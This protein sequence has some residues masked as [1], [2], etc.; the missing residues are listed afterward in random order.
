MADLAFVEVPVYSYNDNNSLQGQVLARESS[1]IDSP[2]MSRR[3]R[4]KYEVTLMGV[5]RKYFAGGSGSVYLC[6]FGIDCE[7]GDI[8]ANS[9]F[10]VLFTSRGRSVKTESVRRRKNK[11][12]F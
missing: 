4:H 3:E 12:I 9:T 6:I 2:L 8:S 5:N 7:N 1:V 11:I 10:S